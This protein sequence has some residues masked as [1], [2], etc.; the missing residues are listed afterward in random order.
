MDMGTA[1]G[2]LKEAGNQDLVLSENQAADRTYPF[3]A[4]AQAVNA[5]P[6]MHESVFAAIDR[7]ESRR[8]YQLPLVQFG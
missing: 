2:P 6:Y 1:A 4:S 5:A 7:R 3:T 8:F